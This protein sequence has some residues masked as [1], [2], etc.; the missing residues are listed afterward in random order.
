[1]QVS[2]LHIPVV[3]ARI[4]HALFEMNAGFRLISTRRRTQSVDDPDAFCRRS[5]H[6]KTCWEGTAVGLP[7]TTTSEVNYCPDLLVS[8]VDQHA[9]DAGSGARTDRK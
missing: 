7:C 2:G 4:Q 5:R 3:S 1:M 9:G 6:G 8:P